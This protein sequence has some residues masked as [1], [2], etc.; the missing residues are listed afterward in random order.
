[1]VLGDVEMA[2]DDTGAEWGVEGMLAGFF[3]ETPFVGLAER[4]R[5]SP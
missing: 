1:M 2:F 4:M 3:A 5:R